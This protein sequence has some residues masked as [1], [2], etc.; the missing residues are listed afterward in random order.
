MSTDLERAAS[1]VEEGQAYL[2]GGRPRDALARLEEALPMF[3]DASEPLAVG[4]LHLAIGGIRLGLGEAEEAIEHLHRALEIHE[5]FDRG[6]EI[7]QDLLHL[8]AAY[9]ALNES[10]RAVDC[11]RRFVEL[12]RRAPSHVPDSMQIAWDAGSATPNDV[13]ERDLVNLVIARIERIASSE[14]PEA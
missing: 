13:D 14:R 6:D 10:Q 11:Y 4:R 3:D 7:A 12:A 5:S 1:L 8:G 9:E 2:D